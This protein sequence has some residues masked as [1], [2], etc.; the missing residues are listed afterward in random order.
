LVTLS[1]IVLAAMKQIKKLIDNNI[2]AENNQK[3]LDVFYDR[4]IGGVNPISLKV[5]SKLSLNRNNNRYFKTISSKLNAPSNRGLT[6]TNKLLSKAFLFFSEKEIGNTGSE[7]AQFIEKVTTG[8]FFTKIVVGDSLNAYTVFETLNARGVQLSTPDLLKNYIFSIIAQEDHILDS[9][10][11]ELDES[12]SE[13][14]SQLGESNFTDFIR[15]HNNFRDKLVTKKTLFK[16]LKTQI[17]NATNAYEY[18]DSLN[19]YSSIYASLLN[20]YDE[21][22]GEGINDVLDRLGNL[23]LLSKDELKR[24]DFEFKKIEYSKT[25]FLLA[26]K[27]TEY[28]E[29]N[30]KNLNHYQSWLAKQAVKT[31]LIDFK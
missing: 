1:L 2:D 23:I 11:N 22:F 28:D 4:L 19:Q 27:I 13:I 20:P 25:D 8:I 29:W 17:T 21:Y 16:I 10:L 18:L 14:I 31:W 7:I 24:N 3:R 26:R 12:W 15:Y 30:Q 5:D 9:D 6:R